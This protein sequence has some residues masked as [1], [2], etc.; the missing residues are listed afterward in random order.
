[1]IVGTDWDALTF[2]SAMT[3][4]TTSLSS[5][6]ITIQIRNQDGSYQ[7]IQG[8]N[9]FTSSP[10]NATTGY[11]FEIMRNVNFSGG[12]NESY[13]N[14]DNNIMWVDWR[15]AYDGTSLFLS[16]SQVPEPS[17]W[18]MISG[19][20]GVLILSVIKRAKKRNSQHLG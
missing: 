5:N 18:F 11:D 12:F 14:L 9:A 16:Y 6:P 3:I 7:G 8:N 4:D 20:A 2:T 17:T 15:I 10:L 1:M 19:L 13:F